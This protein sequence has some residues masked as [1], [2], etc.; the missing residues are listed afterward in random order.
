MEDIK[1]LVK[2]RNSEEKEE[3]SS[4]QLEP[5]PLLNNEEEPEVDESLSSQAKVE[6]AAKT[7]A[8]RWSFAEPIKNTS[9]D[10]AFAGKRN[11]LLSVAIDGSV[12]TN[13]KPKQKKEPKMVG[14][15]K[16]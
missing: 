16:S 6:F 11:S 7:S 12:I 13:F 4:Q 9:K 14:S 5:T 10:P 1:L 8:C 3:R 2:K 15:G